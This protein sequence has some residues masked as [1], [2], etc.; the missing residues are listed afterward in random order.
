MQAAREHAVSL[1]SAA[2]NEMA[3]ADEAFVQLGDAEA[4]VSARPLLCTF[5]QGLGF[6][7]LNLKP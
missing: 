1:E 6:Q 3:S 4:T 5:L 7:L 2:T